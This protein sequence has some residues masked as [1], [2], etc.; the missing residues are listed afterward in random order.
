ME[1]AEATDECRVEVLDSCRSVA[2]EHMIR[3][4]MMI[5]FRRFRRGTDTWSI[6][7][8]HVRFGGEDLLRRADDIFI[9]ELRAHGLYSQ[10][11]NVKQDFAAAL[12]IS[13]VMRERAPLAKLTFSMASSPCAE[14][15][16]APSF[17][18]LCVHNP[19]ARVLPLLHALALPAPQVEASLELAA[20]LYLK[21][22]I[23]K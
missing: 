23:E 17:A 3:W 8:S 5:R 15:A 4:R 12:V 21:I 10:V 13:P 2:G 7:V 20:D 9:R 19:A 22:C 11:Y 6:G 1:S 18:H 16:W 14:P